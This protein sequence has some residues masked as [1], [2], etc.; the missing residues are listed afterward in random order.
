MP[1]TG[2]WVCLHF[3]WRSSSSWWW[4]DCHLWHGSYTTHVWGPLSS[5][6]LSAHWSCQHQGP[7]WSWRS[8]DSSWEDDLTRFHPTSGDPVEIKIKGVL[9]CDTL[10]VNILCFHQLASEVCTIT[11]NSFIIDIWHLPHDRAL[12]AIKNNVTRLW[13]INVCSGPSLF[14]TWPILICGTIGL[15]M[16]TQCT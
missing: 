12:Q 4:T 15:V 11:G 3:L 5:P 13:E 2:F 1:S 9:F 8:G 7:I 14:L 16:L 6:W 10:P